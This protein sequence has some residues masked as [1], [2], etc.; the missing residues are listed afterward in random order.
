MTPQNPVW[1][2]CRVSPGMFDHELGVQGE[3]FDGS[4]YGLFAPREAVDHGERPLTSGQTVPGL[5]Q[6]EAIERK[7]D[8]VLVE[9]PGQTFQNGSLITVTA[10]QLVTSPQPR[11][12]PA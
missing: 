7:G 6:V 11:V 8:L 12:S 1:L 3:Q 4:A 9:L 2:R 5:V 10:G